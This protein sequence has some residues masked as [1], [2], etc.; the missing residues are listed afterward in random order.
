M[1]PWHLRSGTVSGI[2]PCRLHGRDYGQRSRTG[3]QRLAAPG[4]WQ[5]PHGS[6][7][8]NGRW[9]RLHESGLV[10]PARAVRSPL[11]ATGLATCGFGP[12]AVARVVAPAP[13]HP[14]SPSQCPRLIRPTRSDQADLGLA[15]PPALL[16]L[17]A[18]AHRHARIARVARCARHVLGLGG[19]GGGGGAGA[20]A[21][22]GGRLDVSALSKNSPAGGMRGSHLNLGWTLGR[23]RRRLG[24]GRGG[25]GGMRAVSRR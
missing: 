11:H 9:R 21:G 16:A 25:P 12:N 19:R 18:H 5:G 17:L 13:S 23:S 10:E 2:R 4:G 8:V 20:A 22:G 15:D 7:S 14:S 24:F 1:D 3:R 6:I